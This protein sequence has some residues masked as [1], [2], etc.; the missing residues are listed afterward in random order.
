M[1]KEVRPRTPREEFAKFRRKLLKENHI[2]H[3]I[4]ARCGEWRHSVHLHHIKELVHGG[5]NDA[6]NLIPLCHVCH[7]EWD[8]WDG[9]E[10]DFG[11]FLLTPPIHYIRKAFFGKVAISKHSLMMYRA[12]QR[13]MRSNDWAEMYCDGEDCEQYRVEWER[14]NA[15]FNAYPYSDIFEMFRLYGD[16]NTP[17]VLEDLASVKDDATLNDLKD[18]LRWVSKTAV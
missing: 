15:I 9:G 7:N 18:R 8:Y 12:M 11:T 1:K 6:E 13:P 17:V 14:Q 3:L 16:V 2:E 10:F 5:T 4:C